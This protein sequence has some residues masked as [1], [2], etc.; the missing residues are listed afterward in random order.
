MNFEKREDLRR[1]ASQQS[2]YGNYWAGKTLA[3]LDELER[4]QPPE[5]EGPCMHQ[6]LASLFGP[7]G[8]PESYAD[9]INSLVAALDDLWANIDKPELDQLSEET[10][11]LCQD[12]HNTIWHNQDPR[13]GANVQ[14]ILEGKNPNS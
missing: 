14:A 13:P 4:T 10:Q 9:M 7:S 1:R 2:S 6:C 8:R 3:L 11:L 5:P 12:I